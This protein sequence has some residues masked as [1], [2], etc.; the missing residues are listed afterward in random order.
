[1]VEVRDMQHEA[2]IPRELGEDEQERG[3]VGATGDGD[4]EGAWTEERVVAR[5]LPD[6]LDGLT[7]DGHWWLGWDLNPRSGGYESPALGH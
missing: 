5:E 1:M 2:E 7:R 4:E 6:G 3:G